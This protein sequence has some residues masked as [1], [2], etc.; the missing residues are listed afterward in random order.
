MTDVFD[1]LE[2]G[3]AGTIDRRRFLKITGALAGAAAFCQV[4]GDLAQA[5]APLGGYPFTLGVASGDPARHGAVLWTR[6]APDIFAPDGGVPPRRLPVEW[7]VAKDPGMRRVRCLLDRRQWR[8]D[9]RMVTT[10]SRSDAPVYTFA[11]F[12]VEDARPGAQQV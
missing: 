11:S 7:R 9:L 6:L 8:T 3:M 5:T 2:R 1:V 4:R 12:A 10:V